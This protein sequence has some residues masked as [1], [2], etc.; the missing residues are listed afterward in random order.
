MGTITKGENLAIE[1][2][3]FACWHFL[4]FEH[5]SRKKEKEE[6]RRKEGRRK[7]E[8]EEMFT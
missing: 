1:D 4:C 2:L 8:E 6:G 7:K 5:C 3:V